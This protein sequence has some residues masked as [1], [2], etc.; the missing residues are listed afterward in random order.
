MAL[1]DRLFG[2]HGENADPSV[3][4]EHRA[5]ERIAVGR[6]STLYRGEHV[7]TREPVA[8]KVL[9]EYGDR[10]ADKLTQKLKKPWEGERALA[11]QHPNVV[12]TIACGREHGHYYIVMEYL[13][14]GNAAS[15]LQIKSPLVE[16]RKI[17]IMRQA[18]R[19][20]EY[21][22]SR[23]IIHRDICLRNIMLAADGTAKLIDFGVAAHKN[24]RIR[25]TGRRTGRPAYMAPE[26]IRHNHF[27]ERT[28]IYAFGVA[29][30]ELACGQKP[31][32]T[33]DDPQEALTIVLNTPIPGPSTVRPSVSRPLEKIILQAIDP[34]PQARYQSV[35]YLL[36]DLSRVTDADL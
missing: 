3:Y 6:I 28:D 20:L 23:G 34:R 15:L 17:E 27:D 30:Y 11:L 26:L 2:S 36:D 10:V 29:L 1:L 18:A 35:S 24:D 8:I 19:G 21:V 5:T 31:Y 16:G 14:G 4:G 32:R 9:S 7:R 22:H 33:S 12:R 25:D 13:A